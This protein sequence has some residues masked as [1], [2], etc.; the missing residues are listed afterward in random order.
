MYSIG[1]SAGSDSVPAAHS[2]GTSGDFAPE[3]CVGVR[4]IVRLARIQ[5]K[6]AAKKKCSIV[7]PS[8]CVLENRTVSRKFECIRTFRGKIWVIS[9][10]VDP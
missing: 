3:G 6:V 10:E 8:S 7:S 9:I 5:L 1:S 2:L 4:A